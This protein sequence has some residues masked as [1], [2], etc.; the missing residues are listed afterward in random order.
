MESLT[1]EEK[2]EK[3][4]KTKPEPETKVKNLI[5]FIIINQFLL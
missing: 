5:N 2:R 1:V 3:R 4:E